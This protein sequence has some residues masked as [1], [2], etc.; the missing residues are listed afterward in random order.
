M[1]EPA[2]PRRVPF[3]RLMAAIGAAAIVAVATSPAAAQDEAALRS[4][5]EGRRVTLRLDMPGTSDGVDVEVDSS[6]PLDYQRYGQRLKEDGTAI[7]SGESAIVTLVKVKNDLIE[8]QL[9]GGGFGTFGDDTSTSV[10]FS[11]VERSTREKELDRAIEDEHDSR[12]RRQLERERDELREAR[13]R[14]NRRI[15]AERAWAQERKKERVAAQ[16]LTG[17]SRFNLRYDGSVPVG[18]K[19]AEVMAALQD[20]VDFTAAG[21]P[22]PRPD[23]ALAVA[24]AGPGRAGSPGEGPRKGLTRADAERDLG[25]PVQSSERREGSLTVATLVFV[26]NDQ[27]ITAEF[28]EDVLIRYAIASR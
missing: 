4:F 13:E 21:F 3:G 26:R 1:F 16:R 10:T 25:R 19:P 7:R 22:A 27:R 24:A 9:S 12:R 17:G 23:I 6:R 5:F 28:V 14:E 20:Y 15:E 11:R 18:I 2:K 8:F